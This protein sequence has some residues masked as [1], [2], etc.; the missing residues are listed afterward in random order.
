M[1]SSPNFPLSN[2]EHVNEC[3]VKAKQEA[4]PGSSYDSKKRKTVVAAELNLKHK[5]KKVPIKS[6]DDY[7]TKLLTPYLKGI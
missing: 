1:E 6:I 7:S 3:T 4:K 2:M 5:I